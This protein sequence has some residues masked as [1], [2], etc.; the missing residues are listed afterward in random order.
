MSAERPT[1]IDTRPAA[2]EPVYQVENCGVWE[3]VTEQQQA[4]CQ[5][6]AYRVRTL[7]TALPA[8]AHEGDP[9]QWSDQQVRNF[10]ATALRHVDVKG[11]LH[12]QDIRDGFRV[13]R[14]QA[15][16]HASGD[17]RP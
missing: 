2:C 5:D 4:R 15:A 12:C 8:A 3:D 6:L 7:W 11:T 9:E 13:M 1:Q 10:L 14:E 17:E 16:I